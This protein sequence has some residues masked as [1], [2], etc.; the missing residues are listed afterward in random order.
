MSGFHGVGETGVPAH[1]RQGREVEAGVGEGCEH[2][3]AAEAVSE[4]EVAASVRNHGTPVALRPSEQ[5]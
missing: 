3:V 4:V 5:V 2:H 1:G